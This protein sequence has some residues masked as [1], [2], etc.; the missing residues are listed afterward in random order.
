MA[1]FGQDL[2]LVKKYSQ[3]INHGKSKFRV[4]KHQSLA[5]IMNIDRI[6]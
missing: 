2:N 5:K 4:I 6:N 3:Q 1:W